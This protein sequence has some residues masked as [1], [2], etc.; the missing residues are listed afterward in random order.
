MVEAVVRAIVSWS[1][2]LSKSLLKVALDPVLLLLFSH[3]NM[4]KNMKMDGSE[5]QQQLF[6]MTELVDCQSKQI[7]DLQEELRYGRLTRV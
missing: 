3:R 5:N 1:N 6:K 7:K 2:Y 4:I